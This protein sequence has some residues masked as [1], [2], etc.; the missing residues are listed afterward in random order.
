M[1]ESVK[2]WTDVLGNE[3]QQ[4]Y[5][6]DIL[7][8][9]EEQKQAGKIIYPAAND[10]FNAFKETAFED[11]KVVILGQD[12]YHGP[13]QAHGLSFS[14][15]TGIK[16][17]PSLVNI[18]KE[19][20]NDLK[21][22]IPSHGCLE[23]W[24]KQGVLLLNTSLSVEQ[25]M[26]QSHAKIGWTEFTDNVIRR[27]NDHPQPLVFMLWG[28]HAKNKRALISDNK[29]LILTAAHPSPFSVHQGFFGCQHF[30]KANEFLKAH[31][32][33]PIDWSLD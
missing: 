26:P 31:G 6:K 15:K 14:V 13:G 17:P 33:E 11:V 19:L 21:L 10:I 24:A 23:K 16:P 1:A 4:P 29:H 28:A 25:N 5:F 3:K 27:L 7:R 2:T 9:L 30:S 8:F 20:H 22:P 32:R 12:P 18:F